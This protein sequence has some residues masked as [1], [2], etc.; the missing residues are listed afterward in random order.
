ML[1]LHHAVRGMGSRGAVVQCLAD[2]RPEALLVRDENGL[3]PLHV[4]A[5]YYSSIERVRCLAE[6]IPEALLIKTNDDGWLP[7][8]LAVHAKARQCPA[9]LRYQGQLWQASI[10]HCCLQ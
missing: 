2:L 3:M 6:K 9:S 7:L 8:H 4:A 10:A 5:M 1:P